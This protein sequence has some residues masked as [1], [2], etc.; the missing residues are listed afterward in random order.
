MLFL[1]FVVYNIK[2]CEDNLEVDCKGKIFM[3]CL[4]DFYDMV[5]DC[6]LFCYLCVKRGGMWFELYFCVIICGWLF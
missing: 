1:L 2:N 4:K 3:E 5:W 6:L